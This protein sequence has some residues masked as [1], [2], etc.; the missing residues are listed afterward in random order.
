MNVPPNAASQGSAI[1]RGNEYRNNQNPDE[2]IAGMSISDLLNVLGLHAPIQG[3][4]IK[5]RVQRRLDA[6]P[7]NRTYD[8]GVLKAIER[9]LLSYMRD[10]NLVSILLNEENED[11]T[12]IQDSGGQVSQDQLGSMDSGRIPRLSS[13]GK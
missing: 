4:A 8:R 11:Y 2:E 9:K 1:A 3:G 7:Q 6:L 12:A 10:N 13:L 5:G